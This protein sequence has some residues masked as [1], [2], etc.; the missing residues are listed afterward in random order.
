M[1]AGYALNAR[2]VA[3]NWRLSTRSVVNLARSQVYH[4]ERPPCV[5]STFAVMQRVARVCQRQMILVLLS[6]DQTLSLVC[7]TPVQLVTVA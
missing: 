7:R 4:T 3:E 6:V 1:Q 5:C 2:A